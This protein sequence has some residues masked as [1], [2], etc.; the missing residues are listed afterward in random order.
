VQD[1]GLLHAP[2]VF[3]M[4]VEF[5]STVRMAAFAPVSRQPVVVRDLAVWVDDA[6]TYQD[7]LDTLRAAAKSVAGLDL[8]KDIK[9]FDV[10]RDTAAG[11]ARKSMAFRFWLQDPV[12]TLDDAKVDQCIQRLLEALVSAHGVRQRA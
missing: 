8:V 11:T 7:L 3:E 1:N 5:L 10:W 4:D 2:V 9:L 6:V 12:E